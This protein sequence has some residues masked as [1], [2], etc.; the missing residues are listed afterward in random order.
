[1]SECKNAMKN[2]EKKERLATK[3]KQKPEGDKALKKKKKAPST[4]QSAVKQ[5]PT[6]HKSSKK[7]KK[8]KTGKG[9]A[10]ASAET[11]AGKSQGKKKSEIDDIFAAAAEANPKKKSKFEN[12]AGKKGTK[13]QTHPQV[14]VDEDSDD[15][16]FSDSRGVRKK[17][18]HPTL[19]AL[20]CI[21]YLHCFLHC[22]ASLH[23]RALFFPPFAF[24]LSCFCPESI[25]ANKGRREHSITYVSGSP[26]L[27]SE[28]D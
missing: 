24:V 22:F 1:M 14:Q 28:N 20:P 11:K 5:D 21:A 3:E 12:A 13:K 18:E 10:A 7:Q 6:Q 26:F 25:S 23:Q 9:T 19:F 4:K 17:S 8:S 16:G 27:R 2:K 15:D